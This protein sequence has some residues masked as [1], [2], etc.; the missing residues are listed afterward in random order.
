M[1]NHPI[2]LKSHKFRIRDA[3]LRFSAFNQRT[4]PEISGQVKTVAADLAHNLQTGES[5]YTTRIQ[6]ASGELAKLGNLSLLAGMPVEAYIKTSERTALSY[7]VK[8]LSDQVNRAMR[9]D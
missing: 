3:V 4:T 8:P 9:E 1:D 2:L 7:L 6:I 5:W